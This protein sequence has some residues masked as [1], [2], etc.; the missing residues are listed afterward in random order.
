MV[1][2]LGLDLVA[3]GNTNAQPIVLVGLGTGLTLAM[4]DHCVVQYPYQ[5]WLVGDITGHLGREKRGM[6]L[7]YLINGFDCVLVLPASLASGL[8][9]PQFLRDRR[10]LTK[11]PN[12]C[13]V[14]V[15]GLDADTSVEL[16]KELG[17]TIIENKWQPRPL[18]NLEPIPIAPPL[19]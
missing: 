19:V 5:S 13:W 6:I 9:Y 1:A 16:W 3:V 7:D 8:W 10:G 18:G 14:S 17:A 15:S 12:R 11:I 2:Q 4:L